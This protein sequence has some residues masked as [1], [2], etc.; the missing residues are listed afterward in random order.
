[1]RFLQ[2]GIVITTNFKVNLFYFSICSR[3]VYVLLTQHQFTIC[4][5]QFEKWFDDEVKHSGNSSENLYLPQYY[6]I[7]SRYSL[8]FVLLSY[9]NKLQDA[10]S[11][12]V[13]CTQSSNLQNE[14]E[15]WFCEIGIFWY[16]NRISYQWISKKYE[17][18]MYE[19]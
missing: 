10:I 13:K 19:I 5:I 6:H 16:D 1:M 2:S 3:S 18:N 9:R 11:A 14:Q 15:I 4:G 8:V 7:L 12:N 17:W